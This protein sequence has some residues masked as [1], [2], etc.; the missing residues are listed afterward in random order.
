MHPQHA[1]LM[2]P[3]SSNSTNSAIA[4]QFQNPIACQ[5]PMLYY[6]PSSE[7]ARLLFQGKLLSRGCQVF[8]PFTN[9]AE[10]QG[11]N[12]WVKMARIS[13]SRQ[14]M[15]HKRPLRSPVSIEHLLTLLRA[16]TSNDPF[17]AAIWAVATTTFFGCRRLGETVITSVS[18]FDDKHHVLRSVEYNTF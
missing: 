4:G 18:S 13:A 17:H 10:W 14:G 7:N 2:E 3:E 5:H 16:L 11:D 8:E 15:H 6:A 9:R 1:R 12:T